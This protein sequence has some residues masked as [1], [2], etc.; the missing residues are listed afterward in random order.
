MIFHAVIRILCG[1]VGKIHRS[2]RCM[3]IH[4][5]YFRTAFILDIKMVNLIKDRNEA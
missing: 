4:L 3:Y 2:H 1:C 5:I